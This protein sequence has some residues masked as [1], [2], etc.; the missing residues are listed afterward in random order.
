MLFNGPGCIEL[1]SRL[2]GGMMAQSDYM[3]DSDSRLKEG[4]ERRCGM[5]GGGGMRL[6]LG[7][8][9]MS[10][11]SRR[12]RGSVVRARKLQHRFRESRS[13]SPA[14]FSCTINSAKVASTY[15]LEMDNKTGAGVLRSP[16]GRLEVIQNEFR[17]YIFAGLLHHISRPNNLQRTLRFDGLALSSSL[18]CWTA[19][20]NCPQYF[21]TIRRS[22]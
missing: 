21:V 15:S 8:W 10:G 16:Q 2:S 20:S 13:Y 17:G 5:T 12:D 1:G 4:R 6:S 9:R 11:G 18:S 7:C 3:R 19:A 22:L 14:F